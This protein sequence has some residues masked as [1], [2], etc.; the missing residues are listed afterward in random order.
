MF[1]NANDLFCLLH[2]HV[3]TFFYLYHNLTA[4]ASKKLSNNNNSNHN[5]NNNH[6]KFNLLTLLWCQ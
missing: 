5:N 1:L 4:K 6:N 3:K 2:N